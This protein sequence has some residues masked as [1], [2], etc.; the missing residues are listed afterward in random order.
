MSSK[1]AAKVSNSNPAIAGTESAELPKA[2]SFADFENPAVGET[3]GGSY[4]RLELAEKS[5]SP[6]LKYVKD[7]KIQLESQEEAGKFVM[8][9]VPVASDPEGTLLSMP[10]DAIFV[11]NFK[12][13]DIQVGD[14]FVVA[15]YPDA[16][17][18]RG[19]GAGRKMRSFAVKVLSRAPR[20]AAPAAPAN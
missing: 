16:T 14:T 10:I 13:A 2:F 18:A 6:I 4:A 8:Q 9:K 15:R 17:K 19:K 20:A 12:E 1:T 5:V 7:T 11:K 3:F